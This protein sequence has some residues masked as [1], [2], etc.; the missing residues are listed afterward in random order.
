M[1]DADEGGAALSLIDDS[2]EVVGRVV[3]PRQQVVKV[4]PDDGDVTD[5]A[6]GPHVLAVQVDLE[7]GIARH[8][9]AGTRGT[10][11]RLSPP[12]TLTI[13]AYGATADGSPSGRSSTARRWFSNWR[14]D[15]AV[16]RPVPGVVRTH[17]ELVDQDAA[18]AR[19]EH[20]DR[21][22]AR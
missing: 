17:R 11:R 20:L 6:A 15:R 14:R 5:L 1:H 22:H 7:P 4:V 10:G 21:E 13:T 8:A 19:L 12:R 18:V 9:R 2:R 16:D 3:R